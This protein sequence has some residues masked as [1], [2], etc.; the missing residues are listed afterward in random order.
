MKAELVENSNNF[1]DG[2]RQK[3]ETLPFALTVSD[4]AQDDHPLIFVNSAFKQMTG[5]G[6]EMLGQN[7]RFL[8]GP[9]DNDEARA[10][11]KD[12]FDS[13]NR[14]QVVFHN[15]RKD[16]SAFYNLLLL[17]VL[18]ETEDGQRLAIGSQ[19]DLGEKA[20]HEINDETP[21][22]TYDSVFAASSL[23]TQRNIERRRILA[24]TAVR[25]VQS[26][27]MLSNVTSRPST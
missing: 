15:V 9:Y 24:T 14:R 17:D 7:C 10:E 25:L 1:F 4:L 21:S 19:F 22:F 6:D 8:Q 18:P 27:Y 3:L 23:I 11:V 26:W 12:A 2:L 5:F 20:P 16:G 13:G